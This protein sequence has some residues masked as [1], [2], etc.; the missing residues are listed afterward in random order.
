[1]PNRATRG[2][3]LSAVPGL[4]QLGDVEHRVWSAVPRID[5][6][7]SSAGSEVPGVRLAR[8]IL[9]T[10]LCGY[11][12]VEFINVVTPPL[13]ARGVGVVVGFV[14]VTVLFMLQVA[15]SSAAAMRWPMRRRVVMLV[16]QALV[17]FLPILVLGL[18][19]GGMAGFLAGSVLLLVPG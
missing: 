14:S 1:M 6:P 15:N 3:R 2:G 16:A 11:L 18:L 10:V 5:P 7:T 9:I 19:W 4:A 8:A 12:V 13:P 17:T